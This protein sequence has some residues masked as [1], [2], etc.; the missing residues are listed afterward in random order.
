MD[1]ATIDAIPEVVLVD[2]GS[3]FCGVPPV[4]LN[5]ATLLDQEEDNVN[6]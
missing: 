6:V 3:S 4:E 1:G 2:F 5:L